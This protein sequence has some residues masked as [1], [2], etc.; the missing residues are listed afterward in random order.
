MTAGEIRTIASRPS[1]SRDLPMGAAVFRISPGLLSLLKPVKFSLGIIQAL[2]HPEGAFMAFG[3]RGHRP[4]LIMKRKRKPKTRLRLK[5]KKRTK[6]R[7]P[8][9]RPSRVE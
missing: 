6:P 3:P 2:L 5:R 8:K 4:L 7:R 1:R 9:L